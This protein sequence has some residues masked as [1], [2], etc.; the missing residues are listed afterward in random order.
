MEET[1]P[2]IVSGSSCSGQTYLGKLSWHG[3]RARLDAC[4]AHAPPRRLDPAGEGLVG[5]A[6]L[7]R[8]PLELEL[9]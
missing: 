6:A 9:L 1:P 3:R 7:N 2:R 5:G 4:A 8:T